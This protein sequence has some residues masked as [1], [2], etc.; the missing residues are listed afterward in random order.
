MG[1][2]YNTVSSDAEVG[3]FTKVTMVFTVCS[4]MK[5]QRHKGEMG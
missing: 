2:K 1:P 4:F 5:E 3:R